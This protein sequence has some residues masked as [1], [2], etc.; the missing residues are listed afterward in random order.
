MP[1]V[2]C[3]ISKV[4]EIICYPRH[5]H[6]TMQCKTKHELQSPEKYVL[7]KMQCEA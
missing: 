6:I 1:L 2:A 7:I 3:I 4:S 5:W